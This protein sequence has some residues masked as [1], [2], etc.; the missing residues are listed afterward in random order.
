MCARGCFYGFNTCGQC[1]KKNQKKINQ[2]DLAAGAQVVKKS[3]TFLLRLLLYCARKSTF[4]QKVL[5]AARQ[6]TFSAASCWIINI[7][8][9]RR[10]TAM[11]TL[12][13]RRPAARYGGVAGSQRGASIQ[14]G[15]RVGRPQQ[16][17][18]P[19]RWDG[20]RSAREA[21]HIN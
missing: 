2:L 7:I 6:A 9:N 5:P 21:A 12:A 11:C 19:G 3:G 1:L 10:Q 18:Q 15:A 17:Q 14:R 20:R 4:R 8:I 13:R 16:Q